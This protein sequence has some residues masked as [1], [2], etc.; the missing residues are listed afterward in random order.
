MAN[1][2]WLWSDS[3]LRIKLSKFESFLKKIAS[4]DSVRYFYDSY[5]LLL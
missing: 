3:L 2:I 4:K 5:N 1:V